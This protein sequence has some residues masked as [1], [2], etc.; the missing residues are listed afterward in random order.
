MD[1]NQ[2][3]VSL[4]YQELNS[5]FVFTAIGTTGYF[6]PL[7]AFPNVVVNGQVYHWL[8]NMYQGEHLLQLF[9]YNKRTHT[10]IA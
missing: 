8:L 9:L 3:Q 5:G 2:Q 7:N 6:L 1:V 4:I 10:D